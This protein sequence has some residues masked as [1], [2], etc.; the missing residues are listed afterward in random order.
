MKQMENMRVLVSKR[1][2]K[3]GL[4][5]CLEQK[6]IDKISVSELCREAQ[7]NRATFYN[8]YE[9]PRD[10]LVEIGW[11]HAKEIKSLFEE[12]KRLPLQKKLVKVFTYLYD[13]KWAV[14]ILFSAGADQRMVQ[15]MSEV[16][17]WAWA[18]LANLRKDL[19]LKDEVEVELA[20]HTYGWAA[21]FLIGKW[22]RDDIE[23]SPEEI[24]ELFI[25][26]Q[27]RMLY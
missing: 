1:M 26:L 20:S 24:A 27:G 5:R 15:S 10:I 14:N 25:K 7:I 4:L 3:E 17:V 23:K 9:S 21:Y 12:E 11:E 2:L 16:F 18:D 8:H 19:Q 6:P 13:N 22:L